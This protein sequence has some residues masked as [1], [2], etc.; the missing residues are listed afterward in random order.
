[1][2]AVI[3]FLVAHH[4]RQAGNHTF[5]SPAYSACQY[6]SNRFG[7]WN[8]RTERHNLCI[9]HYSM[10]TEHLKYIKVSENTILLYGCTSNN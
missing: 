9:K 8:I 6:L 7:N 1:M 2:T 10:Q 4:L 3:L 5:S